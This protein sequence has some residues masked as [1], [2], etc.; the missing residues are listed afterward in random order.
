M[1]ASAILFCKWP[2]G[3]DSPVVGGG[4]PPQLRRFDLNEEEPDAG[5]SA[6]IC[7]GDLQ[8]TCAKIS[9]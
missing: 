8:G 4:K 2:R 9:L 3:D 5:P 6:Q 7:G 1:T